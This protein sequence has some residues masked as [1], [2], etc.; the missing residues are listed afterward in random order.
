MM[1]NTLTLGLHRLA[2][3]TQPVPGIDIT[4]HWLHAVATQFGPFTTLHTCIIDPPVSASIVLT[5]D[6]GDPTVGHYVLPILQSYQAVATAFVMPSNDQRLTY[7]ALLAAGWELGSHTMT[8]RP[9][10]LLPSQAVSKELK[11]SRDRLQD[12]TAAR[13]YGLA[14]PF[15]RFTR[16]ELDIAAEAGY[17]YVATTLPLCMNI[18]APS[19]VRIIPRLMCDFTTS[20]SYIHKLVRQ[21]WRRVVPWLL[22][23]IIYQCS[24]LSG[25]PRSSYRVLPRTNSLGVSNTGSS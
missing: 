10:D 15:G 7:S 19:A 9:L 5:F 11:E 16:R 6:D 4:P 24:R 3:S 23:S 2:V 8:H 17:M 13:V 18:Y 1:S 25:P 12:Y 14:F 22:D 21:P 20:P